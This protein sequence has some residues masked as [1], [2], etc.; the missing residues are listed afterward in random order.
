MTIKGQSSKE[1]EASQMCALAPRC[2]GI[3][4]AVQEIKSFGAGLPIV[5]YSNRMWQRLCEASGGGLAGPMHRP[6]KVVDLIEE[7]I[8]S[9]GMLGT[10]SERGSSDSAP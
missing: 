1:N 10:M 2:R 5:G 8:S 4:K 6:D 7:L 3:P 9:P